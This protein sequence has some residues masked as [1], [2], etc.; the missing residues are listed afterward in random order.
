MSQPIAARARLELWIWRHGL[1]LPL[2]AVLLAA[3]AAVGW[4]VYTTAAQAQRALAALPPV[5]MTAPA[6]RSPA[7]DDAE[8]LTALRQALEPLHEATESVRRLVALTQPDLAWQR[9]EFQ[10]SD[11]VAPG[12]A[13][14]Q[15]T[16]PVSGE[17]RALRRA[18]DRA[19][20]EMPNLSLDQVQFRREQAGESQLDTRLRFSLWLQ[21]A[22]KAV[23]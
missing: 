7:A 23:P 6:M 1:W 20:Q 15:I 17:Y 13:R 9:A 2:L 3:A 11:D 4:D 12:V 10:Q 21:A 16:V 18:L 8:R 22:P 14:L 19:L 5:A